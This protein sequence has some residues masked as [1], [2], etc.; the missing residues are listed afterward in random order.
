MPPFQDKDV[1]FSAKFFFSSTSVSTMVGTCAA[2]SSTTTIQRRTR[3][4]TRMQTRTMMTATTAATIKRTPSACLEATWPTVSCSSTIRS[5]ASSSLASRLTLRRAGECQ[6]VLSSV[7]IFYSDA[8]LC[9][10]ADLFKYSIAIDLTPGGWTQSTTMKAPEGIILFTWF[11]SCLGNKIE[12]AMISD[13]IIVFTLVNNSLLC[14]IRTWCVNR[15]ICKA[16]PHYLIDFFGF[17]SLSQQTSLP[18]SRVFEEWRF[19]KKYM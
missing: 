10:F 4:R 1:G 5:S 6:R 12:L 11:S 2:W 9:V 15:E 7:A 18:A 16:F 13:V 3:R 14:V 8:I 19:L 17:L